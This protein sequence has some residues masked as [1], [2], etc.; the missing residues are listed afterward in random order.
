MRIQTAVTECNHSETRVYNC[1][2]IRITAEPQNSITQNYIKL[3]NIV[4]FRFSFSLSLTHLHV[5][6]LFLSLYFFSL[7]LFVLFD[8]CH[9]LVYMF[10]TRPLTQINRQ[11]VDASSGC[12]IEH[13][14]ATPGSPSQGSSIQALFGCP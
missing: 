13:N 5:P 8:L 10:G 11:D 14:S 2:F 12:C 3:S 9:L 1:S 6:F 7:S 4:K